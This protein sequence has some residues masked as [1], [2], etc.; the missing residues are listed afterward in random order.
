MPRHI[1]KEGQSL[2]VKE[3][4]LK[5]VVNVLFDTW[6]HTRVTVVAC[7][8]PGPCS[9]GGG[10]P[11]LVVSHLVVSGFVCRLGLLLVCKCSY[12]VEPRPF[13]ALVSS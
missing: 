9:G 6:V 7:A 5:I 8:V 12:T 11:V 10:D 4:V 3:I 1:Y 13:A 2:V